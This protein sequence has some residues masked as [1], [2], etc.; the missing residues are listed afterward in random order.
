MGWFSL[1]GLHVGLESWVER[2]VVM[3]L[4]AGPD[5]A[6]LGHGPPFP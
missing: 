5:V 1:A 2:D 4:D 6:R 3:R